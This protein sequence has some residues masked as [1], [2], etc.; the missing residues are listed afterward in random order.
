MNDPLNVS[1]KQWQAWVI[2]LARLSGY[3]CYHPYD[4]RRSA[5]G[6]PDITL[7]RPPRLIFAELKTEKGKPT[8]YQQMWGEALVKC[9]GVE[10]YLWRPSQWK[11]VRDILHEKV[12]A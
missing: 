11:E 6:Y 2:K 8:E 9:P 1:E 5:Y 12:L 4:S 10:Y 3:L 7:V